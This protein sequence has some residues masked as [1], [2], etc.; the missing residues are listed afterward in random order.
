MAPAQSLERV[1]G[2]ALLLWA[3]EGGGGMEQVEG[4]S[5]C[6][7]L[8]GLIFG[9]FLSWVLVYSEKYVYL[10]SFSSEP[11]GDSLSIS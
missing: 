2:K 10:Q 4:W 1:G 7:G 6:G 11:L 3:E 9:A 8:G 5:T